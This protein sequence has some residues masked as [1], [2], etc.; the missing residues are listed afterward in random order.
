[1]SPELYP[2]NLVWC[3]RKRAGRRRV[4]ASHEPKL[5]LKGDLGARARRRRHRPAS[6][7]RP[8][9]G[10]VGH[11][12]GPLSVTS[13]W[14]NRS[15]PARSRRR[16]FTA[17]TKMSPCPYPPFPYQSQAVG[18]SAGE[19]RSAERRGLETLAKRN[20]FATTAVGIKGRSRPT[21]QHASLGLS[22]TTRSVSFPFLTAG[23]V[24]V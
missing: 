9:H 14:S 3:P 2:G 22:A 19:L 10:P 20:E 23:I 13:D 16:R 4:N 8:R 11:P 7:H 18:A 5:H 15:P 12:Q 1:M 24:A 6:R 17:P 21:L